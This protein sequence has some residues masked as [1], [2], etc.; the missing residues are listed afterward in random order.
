MNDPPVK[1]D[2]DDVVVN[3]DGGQHSN[4]YDRMKA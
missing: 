1:L 4:I 2:H 3:D